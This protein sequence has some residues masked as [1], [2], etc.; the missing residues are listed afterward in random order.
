[1]EI[2]QDRRKQIQVA[3]W[4]IL[5]LISYFFLAELGEVTKLNAAVIQSLDEKKETVLM[6]T[7]LTGTTSTAIT[8]IPGDVGGP[9]A[10]NIADLAD[11]LL[12]VF[13]G[14]W[15]QKYLVS[16]TAFLT[17]K[18]IFPAACVILAS[19]VFLQRPQ[20]KQAA[21]KLF[22]F[23][24]LFFTVVP[25][26]VSLSH[27]IEATYQDSIE[28]TITKAQSISE[29]AVETAKEKKGLL[30]TILNWGADLLEQFE[31][32]LGNMMEAVVVL[33][34]TTCIIPLLVF[35]LFIWGINLIFGLNLHPRWGYGG[36][37]R[38][39]HRGLKKKKIGKS[40]S[41][42]SV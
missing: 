34:V 7:T 21:V 18:C 39:L 37:F 27:H 8:L 25:A 13:A 32:A 38:Q 36:P 29:E 5:A 42:G 41:A 40:K 4:L 9:L 6:L 22:L 14:I 31:T 10:Q 23:G 1:M 19:N 33:I 15:L 12:L 20:L 28:Q 30:D 11:Y 2:L 3:T 26:S 17:F 35:A 24:G 16:I